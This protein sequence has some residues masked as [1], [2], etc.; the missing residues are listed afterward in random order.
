LHSR[1]DIR[2]F[3]EHVGFFTGAC[4]HYYRSRIDADACRELWAPGLAADL[5]D[6]IEHLQACP[7]RTF[8]IV[9]VRLRI[10]KERHH[11]VAEVFGDVASITGD[12]FGGGAMIG[13]NHLTPFLGVELSG[14]FGRSN[15]V[16]KQHGQMS[17]L[18]MLAVD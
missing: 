18:A 13:S 11:T 4:T 2:R 17:P 15:Q 1:S 9:V 5:G 3:A 16:T 10:A 8:R 14:D 12:R 6:G 7:R